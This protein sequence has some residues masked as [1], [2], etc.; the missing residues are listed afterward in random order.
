MTRLLIQA[1]DDLGYHGAADK[2]SQESGYEVESSA[3]AQFREAVLQGDWQQA[4]TLLLGSE[5]PDGGGGVSIRSG[6]HRGLKL[7]DQANRDQLR[8]FLKTQKYL[9]LLEA[10]DS[11]RAIRVLQ[12]ELTPLKPDKDPELAAMSL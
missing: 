6:D 11:G 7:V 12:K 5:P 3:V 1:L 10:G 4:E 9:E 2:L 8:F